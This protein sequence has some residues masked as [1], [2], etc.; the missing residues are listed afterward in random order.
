MPTHFF[1]QITANTETDHGPDVDRHIKN[2]ETRV[3]TRIVI[4]VKLADDGRD[5][6]LQQTRANGHQAQSKK[7]A[8]FNGHR[9]RQVT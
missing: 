8:G 6:A 2:R 5:I 7:Q 3:T 1:A 9:Q 4:C